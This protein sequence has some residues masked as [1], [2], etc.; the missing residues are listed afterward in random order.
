MRGKGGGVTV[1]EEAVRDMK[2]DIKKRRGSGCFSR[3]V[4]EGTA[5]EFDPA[6]WR[7]NEDPGEIKKNIP[8]K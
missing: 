7:Y 1:T 3:A 6:S 2:V 4:C 8:K 5:G